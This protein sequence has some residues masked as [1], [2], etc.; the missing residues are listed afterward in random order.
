MTDPVLPTDSENM[1]DHTE[2]GVPKAAGKT[3]YRVHVYREMRLSFSDIVA[4]S[5]ED[6]AKLAAAKSSD[7]ADLIE[8]CDGESFAALVDVQDDPDY[9]DS[10]TIDFPATVLRNN[11]LAL[12]RALEISEQAIEEATDIMHYEDGLPVTALD[13]WQIERA[14]TAL[15]SVLVQ[16]HQAL[17]AAKGEKP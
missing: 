16:V 6:A 2:F 10:K 5:H 13:G 1:N 7:A 8:D 9:S 3:R 14:Y 17:A 12:L 4:A 11:A 15:C